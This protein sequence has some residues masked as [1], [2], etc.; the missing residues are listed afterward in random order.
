MKMGYT[1]EI[2][3]TVKKPITQRRYMLIISCSKRKRHFIEKKPAFEVYDG[4]IYRSLRKRFSPVSTLPVDIRIVSAKYGLI[5]ANY[6]IK[7]YEYKMTIKRAF[8]LRG[9]VSATL[10][11]ILQRKKYREVFI[12]LGATY[13]VALGAIE[14]VI[15]KDMRLVFAKGGIGQRTSQTIRWLERVAFAGLNSE[16]IR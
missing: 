8:E 3:T 1:E 15:G 7:P 16:Q 11:E 4:P 6:E 10:Y 5:E 14:G 12:N 9:T 13:R 2:D